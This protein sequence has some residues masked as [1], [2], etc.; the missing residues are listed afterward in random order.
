MHQQNF[1][2]QRNP[3]NLSLKLATPN[4][5]HLVGKGFK[6]VTAKQRIYLKDQEHE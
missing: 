2:R 1:S 6:S 4:F 3:D 5:I